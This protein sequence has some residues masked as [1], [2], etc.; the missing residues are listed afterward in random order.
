VVLG[1][2][3]GGLSFVVFYYIPANLGNLLSSALP[4]A[5][6]AAATS[7]VSALIS[8]SL[9]L[10][11]LAATALVF[12]GMLLRGTRA[13]GIILLLNGAVFLAYVYVVFQGGTITL[14]L[15]PGLPSSVSGNVSLNM[16][17]LMLLFFIAPILTVIKGVVLTVMKPQA[18]QGQTS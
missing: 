3:F 7:V 4:A 12:L 13:Y 18:V 11:G 15:P 2:V 16:S 5:S 8:S 17:N 10:L 9:P 14:S 6:R 1:V